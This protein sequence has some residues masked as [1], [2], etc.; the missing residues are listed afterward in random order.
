MVDIARG[1]FYELPIRMTVKN[2]KGGQQELVRTG[3][4][5]FDP[6]VELC[7]HPTVIGV[8]ML[9]TPFGTKAVELPYS[10]VL[11]VLSGNASSGT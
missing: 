2:E 6:P 8:T 10:K 9:T 4:V 3:A 1:R 11:E 5:C 7:P